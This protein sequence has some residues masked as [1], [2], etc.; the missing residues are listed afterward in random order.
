MVLRKMSNFYSIILSDLQNLSIQKK[1]FSGLSQE[2]FSHK[3]Q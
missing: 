1:S 2:H 3:N